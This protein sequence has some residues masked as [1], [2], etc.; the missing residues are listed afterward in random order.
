MPSDY[1]D[2][3][4]SLPLVLW[5]TAITYRPDS[6]ASPPKTRKVHSCSQS[7]KDEKMTLVRNPERKRPAVT[8]LAAGDLTACMHSSRDK[9]GP[10]QTGDA[11]LINRCRSGAMHERCQEVASS[12]DQGFLH[13]RVTAVGLSLAYH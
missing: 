3:E 2:L 9:S 5:I 6:K 8:A 12:R 13:L 4:L 11:H 10:P 7:C 1:L